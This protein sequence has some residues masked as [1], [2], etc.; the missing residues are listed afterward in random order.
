MIQKQI[1]LRTR[2]IRNAT[3]RH[4]EQ[5]SPSKSRRPV[6]ARM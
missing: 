5:F 6:Y 2:Y 3:E 1:F 4:L